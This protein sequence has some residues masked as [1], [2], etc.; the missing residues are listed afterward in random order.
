MSEPIEDGQ[1]LKFNGSYM[2]AKAESKEDV[3]KVLRDDIYTKAGVWDLERAQILPVSG[4]F[5][6]LGSLCG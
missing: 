6:G 4:F 3:L 2:I 1:S 5:I